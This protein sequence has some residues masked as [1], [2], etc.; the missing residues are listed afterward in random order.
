MLFWIFFTINI[1]GIGAYFVYFYW[2]LKK[3]FHSKE[4][5]SFFCF[6]CFTEEWSV[7][8]TS[9]L[10]SLVKIKETRGNAKSKNIS[11]DVDLTSEDLQNEYYLYT[12]LS[13]SETG[14]GVLDHGS[15]KE[16]ERNISNK[17]GKYIKYLVVQRYEIGKYA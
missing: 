5:V 17:R 10:R 2:Y 15:A 7:T 6:F 14:L 4:N 16:A 13:N 1:S 9:I 12:Q 11:F 3:D 8:V